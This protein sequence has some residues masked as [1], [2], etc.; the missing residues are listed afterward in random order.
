MSVTLM[1]LRDTGVGMSSRCCDY[2]CG[3]CSERSTGAVEVAKIKM[4][5][6]RVRG[7]EQYGCGVLGIVLLRTACWSSRNFKNQEEYCSGERS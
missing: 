6:A 1:L 5:T 4:S 2:Q 7:H 3:Y